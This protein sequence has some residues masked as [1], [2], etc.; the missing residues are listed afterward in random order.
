MKKERISLGR[1]NKCGD[2]EASIPPTEPRKASSVDSDHFDAK[3]SGAPMGS[4]AKGSVRFKD[5]RN[6]QKKK[7]L[8][9]RPTV[10]IQGRAEVGSTTDSGDSEAFLVPQLHVTTS[11]TSPESTSGS[12]NPHETPAIPRRKGRIGGNRGDRFGLRFTPDVSEE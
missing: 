6:S 9:H 8:L 2:V 7:G 11:S 12:E 10:R 5:N 3:G 1:R 4:R